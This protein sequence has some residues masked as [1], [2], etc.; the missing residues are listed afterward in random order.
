[1]HIRLTDFGSGV[2]VDQETT[3]STTSKK[4]ERRNSFV[5]TAQFVAPE[6]IQNSPVH[7]GF[8]CFCFSKVNRN[9]NFCPV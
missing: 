3:D 9:E 6:I 4:S 1:M 5:G 7:F 8:E 2:I